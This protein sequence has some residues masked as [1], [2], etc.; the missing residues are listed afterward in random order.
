[1]WLLLLLLL[2][3]LVY[4]EKAPSNMARNRE[5]ANLM[6][7]R[8]ASMKEE[9]DR[10]GAQKDR[11]PF[12]ASEVKSLPDAE[13]WRRQVIGEIARKVAEIQ[14]AGLG[15]ARI[16]D[17]NDEINKLLREKGHW[18]RQIKALKGPD[19]AVTAP[20]M[21]DA[22]GKEVAGSGGYKYFG[23]AKDL[24]GVRELLSADAGPKRGRTRA[25]I[26]RGITPDYYGYRDEEDGEL[27]KAEAEAEKAL[28][29]RAVAEYDAA[30]A[31]AGS[32]SQGAKRRRVEDADTSAAAVGGQGLGALVA[33]YASED[34]DEAP[35]AAR[36]TRRS[37]GVG[38]GGGGDGDDDDVLG[39]G[40][41]APSS[42]A[43]GFRAHVPL[44][45]QQEIEAALL[46]RKRQLLLAKYVGTLPGG[47]AAAAGAGSVASGN[48]AGS[49]GPQRGPS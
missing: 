24:P 20:K 27:V 19:Y 5:K 31:V 41:G 15:E 37:T 16:R 30:K 45:S 11:R 28:H 33:D 43:G 1:L 3:L 29:A 35:G 12:L 17:L 18:E 49:I 23:A 7:N 39:D 6:F 40:A 44:P 10:G 4:S 48:V 38:A 46:E 13:R 21:L 14:N 8:W 32:S 9:Q 36:A 47:A 42:A 26:F 22:E 25:E 2:L 34:D